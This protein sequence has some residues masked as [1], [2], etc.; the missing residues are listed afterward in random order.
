MTRRPGARAP[1]ATIVAA[2][3]TAGLLALGV[4]GLTGSSYGAAAASD[5]L[6]GP[7]ARARFH[8]LWGKPRG[9]RSD[10]YSVSL[11]LAR[12]Q[13]LAKPS[14]PLVHLGLGLG[15]LQRSPADAPVLDWGLAFRP[16]SWPL[17]LRDRWSLGVLWFA[18]AALLFAGV[19]AWLR[20]LT[21]RPRADQAERR[22]RSAV[23]LA[24]AL[25]VFFSSSMTWWLSSALAPI[26]A[27]AGL[28]VW[29][30]ARQL[31]AASTAARIGWTALTAWL[32]A[33]TFFWLYPPAWSPL[34][35]LLSAALLDT[36]RR[37]RGSWRQAVLAV[38]PLL[39][40]VAAG[41]V[42]SV[43]YHAPY[44]ALVIDTV[45]PGRRVGGAGELP[46]ELLASSVWPS[47]QVRTPLDGWEAYRGRIAW[48]NV[49][50]A[51]AVEALPAVLLAALALRGGPVRDAVRRA[52]AGAPV[53]FLAT[54]VL[55]VWL[56]VPL[57][58]ALGFATLL[59][60]SVWPRVWFVAGLGCALLCGVVLAEVR[61]DG[62]A[63]RRWLDLVVAAVALVVTGWLAR[64]QV[65]GVD[66]R[67]RNLSLLWG[68]GALAGVA[69]L[70][71]RAGSLLIAGAWTLSLILSDVAVNPLLPS[72]ELFARGAGHAVVDSALQRTGGRVLDF[73]ETQGD[74][75]AGFGWPILGGVRVAPD[76]GLA[77]FLAPDSPGLSEFI[78]NRYAHVHFVLPPRPT[79]LVQGDLYELSISP[80]SERLP[81]LGVNHLLT[82]QGVA[83]PASCADAFEAR[84]AGEAV[85][86]TRRR[87][88]ALT[89][90]ARTPSPR[91]AL[92]FDYAADAPGQPRLEPAREA[93]RVLAPAGGR[94]V[95]V[96]INGSVVESVECEG[97]RPAFV[98]AHFVMLP[99]GTRPASCRLA[100]LGT[101]GGLRRLLR[102][103]RP[104]AERL[105]PPGAS[106]P[107]ALHELM[108]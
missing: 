103:E 23:A 95:A 34:L 38:A 74:V 39:A 62:T 20:V 82:R 87:P 63:R 55:L 50:E 64:R 49:C 29:A 81:A 37:Q 65:T 108:K 4:G 102:H 43:V 84:A 40:V 25:A 106:S 85:L 99:T 11:P 83:L 86:W 69:A 32:A 44:L 67:L 56:V 15:E 57:P 100:Y 94:A 71:T 77:R 51:S 13:Q 41:T 58:P 8:E 31:S 19:H 68:G 97:A 3:F 96:P 61:P 9:I 21:G 60:W 22:R 52:W 18:R 75:L 73:T 14:F 88:V 105:S 16:L 42:L 70:R 89:G 5:L 90:V 2:C 59:R 36:A 30:G 107:E 33:A 7:A 72:R 79:R 98:D 66:P 104:V 53:Q 48:M 47:L 27:L 76:L 26:V 17:L 12:A 54:A 78:A 45:Y 35:W 24:V 1:G 80:C 93:L 6:L 46:L 91:T 28:C 10:E 92:D 101:T